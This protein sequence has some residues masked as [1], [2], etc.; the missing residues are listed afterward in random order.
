MI[1]NQVIQKALD[2]IK[3]ISGVDL[4]VMEL[5]GTQA[6]ATFTTD[7]ISSV[8]IRSFI[9]SGAEDSRSGGYQY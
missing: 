7:K 1:S 9:D 3:E 8:S 4:A 2:D 6:A 5:D